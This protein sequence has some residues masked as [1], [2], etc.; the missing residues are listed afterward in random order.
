MRGQQGR[1]TT[2]EVTNPQAAKE[3]RI[4]DIFKTQWK[5]LSNLF[6]KDG[7]TMLARAVNAAIMQSRAVAPNGGKRTLESVPAE[8]I[9]E[10]CIACLHMG[11]EPGA[12][13]YLVPYG[14]RITII[15]SPQ[16]LIKLMFNAGW[17]VEARAVREGDF[18]EHE[19]GPEGYIRHRK[20]VGR[21]EGGVT[22]GYAF[23]KHMSGGPATI[24]V[25]SRD[26]IE[27]YREQSQ[28]K[29][30]P[31]WSNNFEG[32]VR[33]TMI[34]RI[35][36]YLPLPASLMTSLRAEESGGVEVSDEIRE[37]L[38]SMNTRPVESEVVTL[39]A[40]PAA[41]QPANADDGGR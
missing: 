35:A 2:D 22:F 11:L 33:K 36:D 34:H 32:A 40:A 5:M 26:D 38:R 20:A 6:P 25:L 13:A 18:F 9:A 23:A 12:D 30:G 3:A 16:G 4:R 27:S 21:R 31:M 8:E 37:L 41:E 14:P 10:K 15:K 1:P 29:N 24:D 17:R 28:Q 39:P 7:E 19:L